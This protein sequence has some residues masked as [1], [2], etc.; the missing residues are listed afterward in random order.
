MRLQEDTL[1]SPSLTVIRL[2]SLDL[3][4][5]KELPRMNLSLRIS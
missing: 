4:P 3:V 1:D 5:D 2:N